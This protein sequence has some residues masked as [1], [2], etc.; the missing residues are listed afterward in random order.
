M[1]KA[2]TC[3]YSFS[4]LMTVLVYIYLVDGFLGYPCYAYVMKYDF[5]SHTMAY[6]TSVYMENFPE[7]GLRHFIIPD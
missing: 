6:Y 5:D 7:G 1:N 3:T 2:G 4:K